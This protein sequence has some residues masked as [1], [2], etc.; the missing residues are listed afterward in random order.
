VTAT[1]TVGKSPYV[2]SAPE[3]VAVTPNGASA[4]V[5]VA[6]NDSVSVISTATKTGFSLVD[7]TLLIIVI[8]IAL[9][10]IILSWYRRLKKK[11]QQTQTT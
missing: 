2:G 6:G 9:F 3:G 11:T 8:A 7:W 1:V 5:T 10:L 4:Y